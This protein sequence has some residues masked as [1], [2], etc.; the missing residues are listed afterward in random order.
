LIKRLLNHLVFGLAAVVFVFEEWLWDGLKRWTAVL[1]LVPGIRWL[2]R[3]VARLPPAAAAV[4]F[5]LPTLIALPVKI[6]ALHLI[7]QGHALLGVAL[8]LAAKFGATALFARVYVLTRP[9]LMRVRWFVR[10]H[11][12]LAR[13]SAWAHRQLE[14]MPAWR[15]AR[16]RLRAW[17]EALRRRPANRPGWMRR[18]RAAE[19]LQ[20]MR[21]DRP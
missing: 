7:G 14:A 6:G 18:L 13:W 11:D 2:E 8:I 21:R 16:D 9:A 20:R 4:V 10:L 5:A 15:E 17:R 19:R 3:G 1:G 12:A